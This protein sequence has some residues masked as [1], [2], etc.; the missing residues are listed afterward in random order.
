MVASELPLLLKSEEMKELLSNMK[1]LACNDI[2]L[3]YYQ[4]DNKLKIYNEWENCN[5]VM[6]KMPTGT[7]KTR[8]FVSIVKNILSCTKH[9]GTIPAV[10]LLVHRKELVNQ[11]SDTLTAYNLSYGVIQSCTEEKPSSHIQVASV[12]SLVR[13]LDRWGKNVFDFIIIDEAHHAPAK[14]YMKI[15]GTFPG[16]KLLGVTA[17]PYRIDG[18]GFSHIFDKLIVSHEIRKFISSG[19]LSNY[20]YYS[21][22]PDSSIVKDIDSITDFEAND[23]EKKALARYLDI[24]PIRTQVVNSYIKHAGGKKAIIYTIN[25][26][27][28]RHL[29]QEYQKRGVCAAAIDCDT[30]LHERKRILNAFRKDEIRVLCNVNLFTEGFDCPDVEVVQLARATKSLSLFLQQVGR[31]LRTSP[32][33][34]KAILID[35]VGLYLNF[36]LPSSSR[37]WEDFFDFEAP[38]SPRQ[39]KNSKRHTSKCSWNRDEGN[40]EVQLIFSTAP[41][42]TAE[43]ALLVQNDKAEDIKSFC[44]L[45]IYKPML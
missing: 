24:E 20:D 31:G 2:S 14:N 32:T 12:Q 40:E 33:K 4:F 13:R 37:N 38:T 34:K 15:L 10:L 45:R 1:Q 30:P 39:A 18:T 5:S 16:A 17:T 36:G 19:F 35:N 21:V 41:E 7:G 23:Y 6:L 22:P 11:I 26:A 44:W 27:H 25:K 29:C 43:K 42:K 3:R 8:M 28:N 9:D